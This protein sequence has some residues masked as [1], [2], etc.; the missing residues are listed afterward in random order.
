[1]TSVSSSTQTLFTECGNKWESVIS[2]QTFPMKT[3]DLYIHVNFSSLGANILG[4][5]GPTY[6][7]IINGKSIPFEG[8]L[9][10]NSD[11][12]ENQMANIKV[13]GTSQAYY[14]VLHEIGHILGIGTMWTYNNLVNKSGDY[15]GENA[16]REYNAIFNLTNNSIIPIED[17]G[18]SGTAGGHLEEGIEPGVS[19]ASILPGLDQEL[20]TGYSESNKG[21]QPLS[22]ITVGLL[23]D[24]GFSVNYNNADTFIPQDGGYLNDDETLVITF[25]TYSSSYTFSPTLTQGLIEIDLIDNYGQY[26]QIPNNFDIS[27]TNGS[28]IITYLV[29]SFENNETEYSIPIITASGQKEVLEVNNAETVYIYDYQTFN[30]QRIVKL[31]LYLQSQI[32]TS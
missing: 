11:S 21:G 13:D 27:V 20:M 24:I 10:M 17:D 7:E 2:E 12:W 26:I 6:Y 30:G 31:T 5:A 8:E 22:K 9:N 1:M 32:F 4:S 14:T 3:Y 23:E 15:D 25:D 18:G 28:I 29:V 16:V 19:H